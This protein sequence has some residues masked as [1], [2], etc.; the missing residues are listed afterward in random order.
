MKNITFAT[1]EAISTLESMMIEHEKHVMKTE[2]IKNIVLKNVFING[3]NDDSD[4]CILLGLNQIIQQKLYVKGY[5]SLGNGYFVN[6]DKCENVC[7]LSILLKNEDTTIKEKVRIRELIQ[8]KCDGS[9]HWTFEGT[10]ITGW[11][12]NMTLD[13]FWGAVEADAV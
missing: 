8:E 4:Y 5:R 1:K 3:V 6:L 10:K 12:F 9:G 11:D 13:E 7:Y 2:S